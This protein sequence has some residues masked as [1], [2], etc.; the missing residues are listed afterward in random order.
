MTAYVCAALWFAAGALA[1]GLIVRS[2]GK[3]TVGDLIA[4]PG[5]TFLGGL[6]LLV[7]LAFFCLDGF[8]DIVIVRWRK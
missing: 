6:S 5:V 4:A 2:N 3:L 1:F 8:D 7:W